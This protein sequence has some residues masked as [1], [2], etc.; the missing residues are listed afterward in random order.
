MERRAAWSKA[1]LLSSAPLAVVFAFLLLSLVTS[2]LAAEVSKFCVSQV[3]PK[4]LSPGE[5]R[6]VEISIRNLGTTEVYHVAVEVVAAV[7]SPIKIVGATRKEIGTVAGG[8]EASVTYEVYVDKGA[9]VG[10]YYIPLKVFWNDEWGAEGELYSE[11]I[12]F[13][14]RVT[15][16]LK[17]AELEVLSVETVPE[18]VE[19]GE[20]FSLRI[21]LRNVGISDARNL[22]ANISVKEPFMPVGGDVEEYLGVLKSGEEAFV[23]FNFSVAADAKTSQHVF[24][25]T[26]RYEDETSRNNVERKKVGVLVRGEPSI[27]IQEITLEPSTLQQ[28]SEGIFLLKLTNVG[29]E[30]AEDVRVEVSSVGL[31]SE[32]YYF[33]GEIPPDASETAAFGIY[34]ADDTRVGRY[35]LKINVYYSD[36]FGKEYN[37]TRIYEVSVLEKASPIPLSYVVAFLIITIILLVGIY[38]VQRRGE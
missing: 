26:L 28:G 18:V 32:S 4:G 33:I 36:R 22:R 11:I 16:S 19:P 30:D 21:R 6:G 8:K 24:E 23:E 14:L 15:G 5:Q 20:T 12:Y 3:S 7:E 17:K 34:V 1:T 37:Y 35:A 31:L 13:S 27:Y 10:V 9:D 29:S 2:P 25:L 38:F